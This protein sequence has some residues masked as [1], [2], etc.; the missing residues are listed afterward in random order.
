MIHRLGDLRDLDQSFPCEVD[1]RLHHPNDRCKFRELIGLHRSQRICFEERDDR[2]KEICL[3][4]GLIHEKVLPMVIVPPVATNLAASEVVPEQLKDMR[5]LLSL[6]DRKHGLKLPS[7]PHNAI[8]LD[9]TAEAAL[10]VD[11]ADD[12]LLDS[13]PFLLI[14]RTRRIFTGRAPTI[15]GG[16]DMSGTA[17]YSGIP[18]YSQLHI[19]P[20]PA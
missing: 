6:Y 4:V 5:A 17:G 2:L 11:E 7:N 19:T 14:A 12:P 10:P 9:R 13:W 8:P 16:S 3:S 15:P 18:A 20:S 1:L